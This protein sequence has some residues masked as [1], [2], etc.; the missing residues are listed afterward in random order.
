M[1]QRMMNGIASARSATRPRDEPHASAMRPIVTRTASRIIGSM[2]DSSALAENPL[3]LECCPDCAY[4]LTGLPA[5]GICPECGRAY[6]QRMIVLYGWGRGDHVNMG[7]CSRE[8]LLGYALVAGMIMFVVLLMWNALLAAVVAGLIGLAALRVPPRWINPYP[9]L[10]QV[11]LRDIGCEQ[12]DDLSGPSMWKDVIRVMNW[13]G[14]IGLL[15]LVAYSYLVWDNSVPLIFFAYATF[16]TIG[17][18]YR[19]RQAAKLAGDP[20][21]HGFVPWSRVDHI[22]IQPISPTQHRITFR[23]MSKWFSAPEPVDADVLLTAIQASEL[24]QRIAAWRGLPT[25]PAQSR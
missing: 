13:L 18:F 9:G 4:S 11:R 8:T 1:P 7:N 24:R 2:S 21:A 22:A 16:R 20:D 15:A 17:R 6:D 10:V 25:A 19:Q 5:E 23:G 14:W 3:R 12:R